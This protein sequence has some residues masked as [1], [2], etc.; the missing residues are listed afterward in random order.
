MRKNITTK[1]TVL[2][3]VMFVVSISLFC[4]VKAHAMYV[5]GTDDSNEDYIIEEYGIDCVSD[6]RDNRKGCSDT[7][8]WYYSVNLEGVKTIQVI[9]EVTRNHC[10]CPND[11]KYNYGE[12]A[13]YITVQGSAGIDKVKSDIIDIDGRYEGYGTLQIQH[14]MYRG[15]G[16]AKCGD[17]GEITF[18]SVR[19]KIC[20]MKEKPTPTPT[21]TAT[22]TPTPTA[23]PTPVPTVS[24][25]PIPTATPTPVPTVT[26]PNL[27]TVTP[28]PI[29]TV[30][31]GEEPAKTEVI[32]SG[33]SSSDYTPVKSSTE[34][35]IPGTTG[36]S[37]T[38][39]TAEGGSTTS[40]T[41]GGQSSGETSQT[42]AG[43]GSS[44]A[45]TPAAPQYSDKAVSSKGDELPGYKSTLTSKSKSDKEKSS[46]A[47]EKDKAAGTS[48]SS[49]SGSSSSKDKSEMT[50]GRKT[51][52]KDGVL[53]VYD[54]EDVA[55]S[56]DDNTSVEEE[57]IELENAY[58]QNDLAIAGEG[59]VSKEDRG[60]LNTTAGII[61]A[62]GIVLLV[63][64]ILLF[65][66]F[67]GVVIFGEIEENDDVFDLCKI[68]IVR[69]KEGNWY[70]NLK[71]VF[72]ENAAVKVKLGLLF[73][74][75][76][77]EWEITGKTTGNYEGTVKGEVTQNMMLLRK[78]IRRN[79]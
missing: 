61:T 37:T 48:P 73:V 77:R 39:G 31:A 9:S 16:C 46:A 13:I 71:D 40:G 59:E 55:N 69:R 6:T 47:G 36:G 29:P 22:P 67:F 68:G 26:P 11:I 60:F 38:S 24:P 12:A 53:Y 65:V 57:E 20:R 18:R 49:S 17:C 7:V 75:F 58:S 34:Y 5:I 19:L 50:N 79:V 45:Y 33:N 44:T 78:K 63:L 27:P 32:P 56:G 1:I 62:A 54:D 41:V 74:V 70:I 25:T 2:F 30:A 14:Y 35:V 28:T 76:F 8:G 10:Q 3:A 42:G 21:P 64:L 15:L 52:M 66:L 72:E 4:R 23:T 51:I 43:T